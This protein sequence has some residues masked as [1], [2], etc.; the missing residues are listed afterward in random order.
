M[1]FG[2][3]ISYLQVQATVAN[4]IVA[5]ILMLIILAVFVLVLISYYNNRKLNSIR[6]QELLKRSFDQ[7]LVTSQL[8]V[9]EQLM[10]Q[11]SQEIHDN[12]GQV[13]SLV[14]LNL[15]TMKPDES[16]KLASTAA[17]VNQAITDLRALSKG[18]NPDFIV[19]NGL[20]PMIRQHLDH[21]QKSGQYEVSL[22][23]DDEP[24]M[25]PAEMIIVY[26]M[27]QETLNNII[28]HAEASVI[29]IVVQQ[30]KIVV[31]DNGR[32]FD[33][34]AESG[35]LGLQ[36]LRERAR[37]IGADVAINAEPGKGTSV[38]FNFNKVS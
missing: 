38:T 4:I 26:R 30:A 11:I 3:D 1:L 29:N 33:T 15:K 5:V 18:L 16:T 17:L 7:A 31:A 27:I 19:K 25:P 28:K 2:R 23:V 32:G 12:V 21:L 35:G 37:L 14:N 36:N 13:L 22:H 6:E 9:Q 24:A 10:R 34:T 8:E 20:L